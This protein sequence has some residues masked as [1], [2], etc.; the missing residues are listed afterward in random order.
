MQWAG[1]FV[2]V[3]ALL[4]GAVACSAADRP[5][6]VQRPNGGGASTTAVSPGST[7]E[8][9]L[10]EA[11][12]AAPASPAGP[13]GPSSSQRPNDPAG[14][15]TGTTT[16]RPRPGS[17]TTT[18]TAAHAT[19]GCPSPKSCSTYVISPGQRGWRAGA[20]GL[21]RIPFHLDTTVPPGSNV[22]SEQIR[23][24]YFRAMD[25]WEAAN[26]RIRFEHVGDASTPA[27]NGDNRSTFAYGLG[28][29]TRTDANGYLIEAD[30]VRS[31]Q[32][33]GDAWTPCEQRDGSCTNTAP[34]IFDLQD[35]LTHELGHVLGLGDLAD[36]PENHSLTMQH[37]P[38]GGE[39]FRCTLALGDVLGLRHLYPTDAPM[40][41]IYDP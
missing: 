7:H 22:T 25:A 26:P 32:S 21:V 33:E 24:A 12:S 2:A 36:T 38:Y 27:V 18:T 17:A 5:A 34:D 39:R 16:T 8:F 3:A 41:P 35:A 4:A 29:T 31:V 14:R 28:V 1:R 30:V 40:P 20:D 23:Q 13:E 37:E 11:G 6:A 10:P 15:N 19:P 9:H